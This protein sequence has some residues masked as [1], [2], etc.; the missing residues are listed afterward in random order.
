MTVKR[1]IHRQ[2]DPPERSRKAAYAFFWLLLPITNSDTN[3]GRH[4]MNDRRIYT[5]MNAAPPFSPT[6]YGK[7]QRFPKPTAEPAIA[8]R[9]PKR[10]L[11]LSLFTTTILWR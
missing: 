6:R 3:I 4:M 10:L 9:A 5:M 8:T 1:P 11:K 2:A 7:R